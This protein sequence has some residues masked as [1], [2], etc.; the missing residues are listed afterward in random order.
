MQPKQPATFAR[1]PPPPE[2]ASLWGRTRCS[3]SLILPLL[4]RRR[5]RRLCIFPTCDHSRR[6]DRKR[7]NPHQGAGR[8]R[9]KR[10]GAI[11]LC[12]Y[13]A[14]GARLIS[15]GMTPAKREKSVSQGMD[16]TTSGGAVRYCRAMPCVRAN[17]ALLLA[18][19]R[20]CA[21]R[22]G[23]STTPAQFLRGRVEK[24]RTAPK[25]CAPELVRTEMSPRS[26][27]HGNANWTDRKAQ[28]FPRR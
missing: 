9:S 26:V 12:R 8:A 23:P 6:V 21:H 2:P 5:Q 24:W 11:S 18:W 13:S 3:R 28:L 19:C 20:T 14:A 27:I 17:H 4:P 10:H 16:S 25:G 15:S 22:P 7:C 1:I